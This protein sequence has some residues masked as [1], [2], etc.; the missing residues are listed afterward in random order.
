[1]VSAKTI[2]ITGPTAAGKTE[3]AKHL[4]DA[5]LSL[6]RVLP[7]T[8]RPM[9]PGEKSDVSYHFVAPQAFEQLI[10]GDEMLEY[11]I[12]NGN[13]YG[14]QKADF[15]RIAESGK[16]ALAVMDI[17]GALRMQEQNPQATVIFLAPDN[18]DIV[19][20]RLAARGLSE[21][22][23]ANRLE[24]AVEELKSADKFDY[25]IANRNGRFADTLKEVILIIQGQTS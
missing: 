8:T 18:L 25:K 3:I 23:I 9:R 22:E 6:A 17:P 10:H 13:Y 5:G 12:Y 14:I 2:V 21:Q 15:K 20:E 7:T 1:M 11:T 4:L 16:I 24:I 19:R